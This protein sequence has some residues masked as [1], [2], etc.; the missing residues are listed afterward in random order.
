MIESLLLAAALLP[1][2]SAFAQDDGSQ[3]EQRP[4]P[5][6]ERAAE[7][8][9][10]HL[11]RLDRALTNASEDKRR[12]R[13]DEKRYQAFRMKFRA[14]LD[15]AMAHVKPTPPNTA[16]HARILS[17]L[18]DSVQALAALG[19]AL[20]QNPDSPA[21]RVALGQVH[22]DRKDYPGA[23]AEANAVLARDPA[24][25]EALALKHFSEGRIGPG[26]AAPSPPGQ[27][28]SGGISDGAVAVTEQ[29][30]APRAMDSP[31]VQA[32]VPR[33]RDARGSGDLRTAMSLTQELMRMEPASD[34]RRRFTGSWRRTTPIGGAFRRPPATSA[35]PKR[36]CKRAATTRLWIGRRRRSKRTPRRRS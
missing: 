3:T 6:V 16:L 11:L 4:T 15:A 32:L 10:P 1:S 19:Q 28:V 7:K 26:G 8:P 36:P 34:T 29:F 33:I 21:L 35:A 13:I 2:L 27:G 24:N 20:K 30:R 23:L 18:G 12:G 9:A 5:A 25:K 22:Y 14:D 31:K 17:R